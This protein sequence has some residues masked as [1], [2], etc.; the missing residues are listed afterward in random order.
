MS[1]AMSEGARVE[2]AWRQ[3]EGGLNILERGLSE[4]HDAVFGLPSEVAVK[5]R[6]ELGAYGVRVVLPVMT[7]PGTLHDKH[8]IYY[9]P[10]TCETR[11]DN[12]KRALTWS[13]VEVLGLRSP[14]LTRVLRD[15]WAALGNKA[16]AE[17]KFPNADRKSVV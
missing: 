11:C 4:V 1:D 7:T 2:D 15:A 17:A 9:D 5:I 13:E 8:K 14:T 3:I 6:E 12:C 10:E 16:E